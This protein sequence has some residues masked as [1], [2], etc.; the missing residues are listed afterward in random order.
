MATP[1]AAQF[2]Y[3]ITDKAS[4]N[5]KGSLGVRFDTHTQ[6]AFTLRLG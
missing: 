3:H 1:L 4:I 2:S 6:R 5:K